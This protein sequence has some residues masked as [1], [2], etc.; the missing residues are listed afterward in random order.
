MA[1]FRVIVVR[2]GTSGRVYPIEPGTNLIGRW[3]PDAGAFPEIDL[4]NEDIEAKVSRKHALITRDGE[5]CTIEDIGSLN[6]TFLNR[7]SRLKPGERQPLTVGDEIIIGKTFLKFERI[8]ETPGE[9]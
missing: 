5:L 7:G 1:I 2:G 3:D 4:E 6:G 9:V 8:D